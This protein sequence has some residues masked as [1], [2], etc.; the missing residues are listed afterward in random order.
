MALISKRR[1]ATL[2][3][4]LAVALTAAAHDVPTVFVRWG[5]GSPAE[6]VGTI[7]VAD[8]AA[9]L[10]SLLFPEDAR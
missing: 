8:T 10:T 2:S 7:G 3:G 6:E 5:Y 1:F 9:E 4:V